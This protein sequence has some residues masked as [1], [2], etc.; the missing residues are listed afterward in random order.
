MRKAVAMAAMVG[1]LVFAGAGAASADANANGV[2]NN[3]PGVLSGNVVQIP[4]DIPINICGNS[5]NLIGLLNPT[6]GNSCSNESGSQST[7]AHESSRS[8]T[9]PAAWQRITWHHDGDSTA[10][11]VGH[12]LGHHVHGDDCC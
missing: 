1:G 3:S 4:V 11:E 10:L 12:H 6:S 8:N 9:E 5:I 7:P 2:A